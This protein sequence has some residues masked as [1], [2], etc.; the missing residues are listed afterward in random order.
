MRFTHY[1]VLGV[2]LV[3]SRDLSLRTG[4]FLRVG[5]DAGVGLVLRSGVSQKFVN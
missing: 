5:L 4:L 1:V 3:L 2:C